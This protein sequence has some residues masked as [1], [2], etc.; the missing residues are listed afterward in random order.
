VSETR[1][2]HINILGNG[3]MSL[4]LDGANTD[5]NQDLNSLIIFRLRC[6]VFT[7]SS[8]MSDVSARIEELEALII[9]YKKTKKKARPALGGEGEPQLSP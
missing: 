9:K 2:S 4:K 3:N 8:L 7:E 1:N 5:L 6:P